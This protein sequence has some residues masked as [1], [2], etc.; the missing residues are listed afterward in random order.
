MDNKTLARALVALSLMMTSAGPSFAQMC[1]PAQV[2]GDVNGVEGVTVADALGVL[3]RS[4]G[5]SVDLFCGCDSNGDAIGALTSTKQTT[6]WDPQDTTNPVTVIDCPGSGQDGE[7]QA[8][9]EPLF[10][11]NGDGTITD[12]RT[13]LMWE[14]LSNDTSIHDYNDQAFLWAGA[15]QKVK[16]L[17]DMAFAEYTDWRVPNIRELASLTDFGAS[18]AV[19]AEFDTACA[20]GCSI[21]TCSCTFTTGDYWSSTTNQ[22][23]PTSAWTFDPKTGEVSPGGQKATLKYVR[24]VRGGF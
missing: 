23:T 9:V 6:C 15:F 19:P 10:Q 24:A 12:K 7:Y 3:R 14:K 2:C 17:N 11:D 21:L 8:G 13:T 22:Q 4:I 1:T 5:L 18:P 20:Q 16:E